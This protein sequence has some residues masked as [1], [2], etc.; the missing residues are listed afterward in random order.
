[1]RARYTAVSRAILAT[2][3]MSIATG[4][5]SPISGCHRRLFHDCVCRI[6]LT[7]PE[8]SIGDGIARVYGCE[9]CLAGELLEFADGSLGL[10]LNLESQTVGA[11][12]FASSFGTQTC[13][14]GFPTSAHEGG[15]S[16]SAT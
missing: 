1:M 5:R 6:G 8:F 15:E 13:T 11:V 12:R 3:F 9:A 4:C 2:G 7:I 10:A 16:K 14:E